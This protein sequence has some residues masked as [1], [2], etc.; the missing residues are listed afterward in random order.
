MD[1]LFPR[2]LFPVEGISYSDGSLA[3][4]GVFLLH[5]RSYVAPVHSV[6]EHRL[7][8]AG[9]LRIATLRF[10]LDPLERTHPDRPVAAV[11]ATTTAVHYRSVARGN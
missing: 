4:A 11:D 2:Y 7:L 5:G 8:A 3:A 1:S 9:A 10:D 6:A